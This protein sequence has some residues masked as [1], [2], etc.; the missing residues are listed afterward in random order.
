MRVYLPCTIAGLRSVVDTGEVDAE[1]GFAVTPALREWYVE[2]DQE[3][4][5]YAA[6]AAAARASLRL[7]ALSGSDQPRRVVLAAEVPDGQARPAGDL[8]A[9]DRAAVRL[10]GPVPL[11]LVDAALVDDP[12]ATDDVRA[13]A[14]A[15]GAAD[16]GDDDASFTVDAVEDHEL[17]WYAAQELAV[18]V[19]LES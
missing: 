8:G 19:E 6:T 5:E 9:D 14:A 12:A 13:A 10:A 18:L 7:I 17:G 2:G 4:L 11:R 15:L 1:V 16:A 3:E